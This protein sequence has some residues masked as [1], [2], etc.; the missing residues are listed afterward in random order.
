MKAHIVLMQPA[1]ERRVLHCQT[2]W[3]GRTYQFVRDETPKERDERLAN[4]VRALYDK[5]MQ[6]GEWRAKRG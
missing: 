2:E 3:D 1:L 4:E 6:F 5:L